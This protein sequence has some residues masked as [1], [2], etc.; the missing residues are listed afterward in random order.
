MAWWYFHEPVEALLEAADA[1]CG[2]FRV[3]EPAVVG[4]RAL[5]VLVDVL[6]I[7]DALNAKAHLTAPVKPATKLRCSTRNRMI[8]GI[9]VIS[10][11]SM[12]AP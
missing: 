10:T 12:S 4:V 7:L 3:P 9:D 2:L 8:V 6:G 11:A 1:G 5:S